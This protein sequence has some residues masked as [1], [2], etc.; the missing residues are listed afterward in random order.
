[1]TQIYDMEGIDYPRNSPRYHIF[2]Q[3]DKPFV[4]LILIFQF[5]CE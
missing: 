4:F 2:M 1:M 5:N 3:K